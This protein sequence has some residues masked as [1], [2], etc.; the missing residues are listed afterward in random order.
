MMIRLFDNIIVRNYL[1]TRLKLLLPSLV[2]AFI[3]KDANRYAS[4]V[5]LNLYTLP[6]TTYDKRHLVRIA[7]KDLT[8]VAEAINRDRIYPLD[9]HSLRNVRH[10]CIIY[11]L[12]LFDELMVPN[13]SVEYADVKQTLNAL[14]DTQ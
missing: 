6:H 7:C 11:F 8:Q 9:E 12:W 1:N 4:S 10:D 13:T 5:W 3:E 14:I 2:K